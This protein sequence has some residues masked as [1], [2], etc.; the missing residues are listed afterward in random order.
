MFPDLRARKSSTPADF[1][2]ADID[3]R[4]RAS[5][6]RL[7]D[8]RKGR[9][10]MWAIPAHCLWSF[11]CVNLFPLSLHVNTD[12]GFSSMKSHQ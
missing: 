4:C 12:D 1:T 5:R 3:D 6:S 11:L 8:K 10:K 2:A 9:R 7:F